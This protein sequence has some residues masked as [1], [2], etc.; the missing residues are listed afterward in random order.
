MLALLLA[1][2]LALGIVVS[3]WLTE[4]ML[5]TQVA[6][7]L[8]PQ[9]ATLLILLMRMLVHLLLLL[10]ASL[11]A[12]PLTSI[13]I[14]DR[15]AVVTRLASLLAL[16]SAPQL[17]LLHITAVNNL[18]STANSTTVSIAVS[19]ANSTTV[20]QGKNANTRGAL[21]RILC[22]GLFWNVPSRIFCAV[23]TLPDPWQT[24]QSAPSSIS[25]SGLLRGDME[26]EG[27]RERERDLFFSFLSFPFPI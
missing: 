13:S 17:A 12:L 14:G 23:F 5:A 2:L 22:E 4:I 6:T 19:T 3:M 8:E 11:L 10:F 1:L 15:T 9:L 26:R 24:L 25:L 16:L 20:P 27:E 21:P 18:F 7:L